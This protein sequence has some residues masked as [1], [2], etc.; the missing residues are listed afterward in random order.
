[1]QKLNKKVINTEANY[2]TGWLLLSEANRTIINGTIAVLA[3]G[4]DGTKDAVLDVY[5]SNDNEN[6]SG[7]KIDSKVINADPYELLVNVNLPIQ[8]I[9]F[10]ITLNSVTSI[11]LLE[12][13]GI[14]SIE[15]E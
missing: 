14:F 1:M 13:D 4:I 11:G 3:T 7:I 2:N 9:M 12:I 10:N 8:Y 5:V 15:M 6:Q